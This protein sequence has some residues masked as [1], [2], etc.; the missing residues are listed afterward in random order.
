MDLGG[1][2][3]VSLENL[4]QT[5]PMFLTKVGERGKE[6]E[7]ISKWSRYCDNSI[8]FSG[9]LKKLTGMLMG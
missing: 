6:L 5:A 7:A 8:G 4:N 2:S 3:V 1:V 9:L